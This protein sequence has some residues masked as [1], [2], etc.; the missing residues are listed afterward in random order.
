MRHEMALRPAPL[1]RERIEEV[2][3]AARVFGLSPRQQWVSRWYSGY[4]RLDSR[5]AL[6]ETI[7]EA[8]DRF[9]CPEH[10]D[11]ARLL[12]LPPTGPT[13]FAIDLLYEQGEVRAWF[14]DM[15]HHF[16]DIASAVPWARR[17]AVG[18]YQLRTTFVAGKPREWLLE[19]SERG[20]AGGPTLATGHPIFFK[21]LRSVRQVVRRNALSA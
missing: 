4:N 1:S 8:L 12:S 5:N 13:G 19:P 2:F 11:R 21:S 10:P 6:A 9:V 7:D 18:E 3:R 20:A 16:D 15:E 14:A 17:G